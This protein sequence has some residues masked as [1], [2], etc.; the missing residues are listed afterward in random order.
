MFDELNFRN[1]QGDGKVAIVVAVAGVAASG[2]IAWLGLPALYALS[3]ATVAL[4][5]AKLFKH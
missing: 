4:V 5:A 2:L 1:Q 3:G